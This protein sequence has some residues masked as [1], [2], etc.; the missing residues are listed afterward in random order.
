MKTILQLCAGTC[1]LLSGFIMQAQTFQNYTTLSTTT[2]LCNDEV[3]GICID[4]E[5]RKWFAT[6]EGISVYDGIN[7]ET[8]SKATG[9]GD[10]V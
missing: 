2:T 1:L 3:R 10:I 4:N 5:G 6:S 7:W 9:L 8:H